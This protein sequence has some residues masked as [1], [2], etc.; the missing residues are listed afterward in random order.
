MGITSTT[1]NLQQELLARIIERFE[2]KVDAVRELADFF[3]VGKDAI[4]RRLRGDTLLTPEEIRQLARKYKIS[5]DAILFEDKDMV[6][7]SFNA[8]SRT[9]RSVDDYLSNLKA[10]LEN[11]GNVPNAEI[12]YPT[13]EIPIFYYCFFPE[14]ISF[15]LYVWGRNIWDLDYLQK[16]AFRPDII[17]HHALDMC[18]EVLQT[19]LRIDTIEMWSLNLF[20][21]TLNQIEYYANTGGFK[22]EED[23][24]ELCDKLAALA[25]HMSAM[26]EAGKKSDLNGHSIEKADFQ[27]YHN[28][29]IST[30]SFIYLTSPHIRVLFSIY[31]SPNY[32]TS[33][34]ERI[35]D[36]TEN[37][38]RKIKA[39]S[40]P[41]IGDAARDR[42]WFFKGIKRRIENTR[43]RIENHLEGIF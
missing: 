41:I 30:N 22:N 20:D 19:Y 29:M 35:C 9:I 34:D 36:Y 23:A 39:R 13:N 38:I 15:K 6:F 43:K 25:D 14:L 2:K 12:Y 33:S 1:I 24:L 7:F 27:L 32:M 8:F 21:N 4:Y 42:N 18:N 37:W 11:F 17:Q 40:T 26:A 28:E 3:N 16:H 10:N 31:G 5:L